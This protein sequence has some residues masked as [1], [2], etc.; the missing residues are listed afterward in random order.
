MKFFLLIILPASALAEGCEDLAGRVG[1]GGILWTE[2]V[3]IV[4][5]T[6]APNLSM[7]S[8]NVNQ[9]KMM[10]RRAAQ[11]DAYRKAVAILSGVRV[12]SLADAQD[13]PRVVS[14]ING[15]V[16]SARVCKTKFYADGGVDVAISIPLTGAIADSDD[17]SVGSEVA[18][19][20]SPYTGL[21][22]DARALSF[23]P[24]LIPRL[25][26][27]EGQILFDGRHLR[28][29][30]LDVGLPVRYV[31]AD[32]AVDDVGTNPFR[33]V[34]LA[35]GPLSPS[36]LV[37]DAEAAKLLAARPAFLGDGQIAIMIR[38]PVA[39]DCKSMASSVETV[40]T[41]W[42]ARLLLARGHGQV[43]FSREQ[44]EA[45][46]MR[47]MERAAEVDAERLLVTGAAAIPG[48]NAT[49]PSRTA[50]VN[51]VRC[52]ARF[53]RDGKSEVVLAVPID[54]LG[55]QVD[56]GVPDRMASDANEGEGPTGI[57]VDATAVEGFVPS[58]AP[59]LGATV[60]DVLYG[61][62]HVSRTYGRMWGGAAYHTSVEAANADP[63][64]GEH[65]VTVRATGLAEGDRSMLVIEPA[66]IDELRSMARQAG[67]LS[68]GAVAVVVDESRIRQ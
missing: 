52:G 49:E 32:D 58:I 66:G 8:R 22:V 36:D 27:D 30:V 55:L 16:N 39:T 29:A 25:L 10:S 67:V 50:L 41:D 38:E 46:Q 54:R 11:I 3:V 15:V 59:R 4:Q 17:E 20:A 21:I 53:F 60:G 42:Q 5:G 56:W 63:R 43:D 37:V 33:T 2:E 65:A 26:G 12:T 64:T 40:V 47:M 24:A 61:P 19:G 68:R 57:V 35:T 44:D 7:G 13:I 6:A 45:V 9:I 48:A 62:S 23:E 34:A 18:T 51:A 28:R 14:A 1:H 31:H